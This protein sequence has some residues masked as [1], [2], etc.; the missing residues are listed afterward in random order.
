MCGG[1]IA[2][3]ANTT[4]QVMLMA[5]RNNRGV[6]LWFLLFFAGTLLSIPL[7]DHLGRP[8][9]ERPILFSIVVLAVV[10]KVYSELYRQLWF[11]LTMAVFAVLHLPLIL[12]VPW[13]GGWI[14]GPI[15]FILCI[16]DVGLMIWIISLVQKMVRGGSNH[17]LVE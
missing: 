15:I 3:A 4:R 17:L 6:I 14:P 11:W 13:K 1:R 8:E 5:E 2:R 12:F 10:L 7:L 16:P 9:L